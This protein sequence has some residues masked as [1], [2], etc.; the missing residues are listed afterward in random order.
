M[1]G[2]FW[3]LKKAKKSRIDRG[4]ESSASETPMGSR[5]QQKNNN[6]KQSDVQP[7]ETPG[8]QMC[9]MRGNQHEKY[10]NTA[11]SP[12]ASDLWAAL[13]GRDTRDE[14]NL[15]EIVTAVR[16]CFIFESTRPLHF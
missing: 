6:S 16:D 2:L 11:A 12:S 15:L 5:T 7:G 10:Q 1:F 8:G 13:A 3:E 9:R 14:C 4:G